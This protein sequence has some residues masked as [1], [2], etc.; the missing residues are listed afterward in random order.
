MRRATALALV[1]SVCLAPESPLRAK[2][3]DNDSDDHSGGPK[4]A[5][6]IK[7]LVVIFNENN[8]F[9]HYF[10]TYPIAVP[11]LDGS[12]YFGTPQDDTPPINGLTPT[13]LTNNAPITTMT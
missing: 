1:L 8:S 5:T 2:A 12:V 6:P 10:A 11:N 3:A 13:L 4:T 7:H 9:D